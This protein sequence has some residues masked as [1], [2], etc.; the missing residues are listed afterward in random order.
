MGLR[1]GPLTA[2]HDSMWS[3]WGSGGAVAGKQLWVE[4]GGVNCETAVV[5]VKALVEV[6]KEGVGVLVFFVMLYEHFV[7]TGCAEHL[8]VWLQAWC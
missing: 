5:K 4:G 2:Q 6:W 7:G 1:P 8:T 3:G